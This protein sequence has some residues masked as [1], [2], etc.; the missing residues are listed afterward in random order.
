MLT[1]ITLAVIAG[2]IA[3]ESPARA[4]T[5]EEQADVD[6][7][8]RRINDESNV[9]TVYRVWRFMLLCQQKAGL[10]DGEVSELLK[11]VNDITALAKSRS[12][13][14]DADALWTFPGCVKT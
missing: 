8:L 14:I 11:A 13:E 1:R 10:T 2:L 3:S 4:L 6:F 12:P 9:F 7:E 5:S